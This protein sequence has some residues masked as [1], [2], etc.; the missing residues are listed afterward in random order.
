[1][2]PP[3]GDAV[4]LVVG[5]VVP[6]DPPEEVAVP[7]SAP[8]ADGVPLPPQGGDVVAEGGCGPL[9]V[10]VGEAQPLGERTPLDDGKPVPDRAPDKLRNGDGVLHPECSEAPLAL[11]LPD[12]EGRGVGDCEVHW[13]CAAVS[14]GC[15]EPLSLALPGARDGEG[16]PLAL[17][18]RSPV[19][20]PL[21]LP[22]TTKPP[23]P[24]G[25]REREGGG[26]VVPL[27]E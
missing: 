5:K 22:P 27:T 14:D 8:L 9:R 26:D 7:L 10:G 2:A 25:S 1:V 18:A 20:E 6:D 4:G 16:G 17:A 15:E 24:V 11:A 23:L 13:E 19:N 12:A 21:A 3:G